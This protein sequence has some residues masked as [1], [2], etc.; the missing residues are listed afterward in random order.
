[1]LDRDT[2]AQEWARGIRNSDAS[3]LTALFRATYDDLRRYAASFGADA[4]AS[5]DLVQETF[6]RMWD[7]RQSIDPERSPRAYLFVTIRNL[8]LNESRR[9][10]A[11]ER[12]HVNIAGRSDPPQ[13]DDLAGAHDL[14][15]R[16]RVWIQELP[17]RRREAFV[18]SRF[19]G[20][21]LHEIG[22]VMNVS[23]KTVENHITQAL[24]DLRRRIHEFDPGL[25]KP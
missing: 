3:A 9:I 7:R 18:L 16:L 13:P 12:M 17:E 21:S 15:S 5:D 11:R 24:K 19:A 22:S 20:L 1:M 25:L 4:S 2:R 6:I 10:R 23:A 14:Q 8:T